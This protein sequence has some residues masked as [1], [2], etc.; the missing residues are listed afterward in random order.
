[1]KSLEW[2]W[3]LLIG[4]AN[5][6]W[7]LLSWLLGMHGNG[8]GMIQ[9][10]FA[11]SF[12]VSLSGYILAFRSLLLAEPET[13]F[14]EGIR[15]GAIIA[16]VS[17]ILAILGQ[18]LYF[19]FLNPGWTDYLVGQTRLHYEAMGVAGEQLE[20]LLTQAE[21]AYGFKNYVIQSGLGALVLGMIFSAVIMGATRWRAKR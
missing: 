12:F 6:I 11:V 7:L 16:G 21:V 8:F 3:G 1:M 5:L 4:G 13:S 10:M 15:S 2:K 14:V 18:V 9:V 17:A 19:T 20:R